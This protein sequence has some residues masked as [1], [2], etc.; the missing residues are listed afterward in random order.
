MFQDRRELEPRDSGGAAAEGHV[1]ER[2]TN[3]GRG[4]RGG[5]TVGLEPGRADVPS[6]P[7]DQPRASQPRARRPNTARAEASGPGRT[8]G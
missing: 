1:G 7:Q 2:S 4:G 5:R 6:L 3:A 8:A